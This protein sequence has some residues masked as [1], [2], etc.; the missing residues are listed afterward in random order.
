MLLSFFYNYLEYKYNKLQKQCDDK[1][2][3]EPLTEVQLKLLQLESQA[4]LL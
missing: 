3:Y 4:E 2:S 1:L